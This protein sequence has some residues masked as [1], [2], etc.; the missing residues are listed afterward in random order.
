MDKR[1]ILA[2]NRDFLTEELINK[3]ESDI[4]FENIQKMLENQRDSEDKERMYFDYDR[5][6]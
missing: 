1:S 4:C 6:E 3:E 2:S 5:E